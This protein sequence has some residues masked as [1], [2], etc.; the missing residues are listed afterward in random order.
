MAAVTAG[1]DP[2]A[3]PHVA[4]VPDPRPGP[5]RAS[6]PTSEVGWMYGGASHGRFPFRRQGSMLGEMRVFLIGA[7]GQVGHELRDVLRDHEVTAVDIAE[8]DIG[9]KSAVAAAIGATKPQMIVNAAAYTDV[10]GAEADRDGAYRINRDAVAHLGEIA[11]ASRAALIHYS[12]DFVFDGTKG[13]PY[14]EEDLTNPLSVYGASKLAGEN[15]LLEL[16]AP[17]MILRTAWV[18]SLRRKSFV[19]A[20]LRLARERSELKIV[21][22]QVGNPTFC[23][24]LARATARL[25]DR[26][27]PDPHATIEQ[28]AGVYHLAGSGSVNRFE[29]AKKILELDPRKHEHK[30]HSVLPVQSSAFPSPARRPLFAPLDC[31][32]IERR[33]G[34][35][36]PP[37]EESLAEALRTGT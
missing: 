20:I 4:K 35:R 26:L 9:D 36:L 7:D 24:D 10:D 33:L 11:R 19:S 16:R 5:I 18:Y 34:I 2:S 30:V 21:E 15:A 23:R 28:L 32:K 1:T 31:S 6:G 37:W 17:A 8:V 25:L 22:D 29:F 12:T 14:T 13:T 3:I 27:T